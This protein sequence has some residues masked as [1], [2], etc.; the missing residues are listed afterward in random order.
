MCLKCEKLIALFYWSS[1]ATLTQPMV[2]VW[3]DYLSTNITFA[4]LFGA[5]SGTEIITHFSF[6]NVTHEVVED[7]LCGLEVLLL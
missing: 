6:K 3:D 1:T 5:T 7:T 2:Q 4:I